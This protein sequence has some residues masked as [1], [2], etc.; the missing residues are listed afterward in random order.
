[1]SKAK[2]TVITLV[3]FLLFSIAVIPAKANEKK[4]D[5]LEWRMELIKASRE[6]MGEESEENMYYHQVATVF[7]TFGEASLN[8][9]LRVAPYV[10]KGEKSSLHLMGEIYYLRK[11]NDFANF[12]SF[13]EMED[14]FYIGGGAEITDRANFQI[15]T[16]WEVTNHIFLELRAINTEGQLDDSDLYPVAGFQLKY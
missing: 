15:F 4:E 14:G 3:I 7:T 13:Y 10:W 1:M 12:I 5:E 11:E 6:M 8:T 16:G 2:I 9:G